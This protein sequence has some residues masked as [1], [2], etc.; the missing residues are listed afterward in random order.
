MGTP[1]IAVA[2]LRALTEVSDVVG[3]VCQPDRRSGRGMKLRPPPVKEAAL[4]SLKSSR[5]QS[6]LK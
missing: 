6:F 1:A 3:V 4:E 5:E 2:S